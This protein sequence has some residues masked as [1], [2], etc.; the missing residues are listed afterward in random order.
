[1]MLA[2][3]KPLASALLLAA[4]AGNA[5]GPQAR[6]LEIGGRAGAYTVYLPTNYAT[7]TSL[8]LVVDLHG[9]ESTPERQRAIS[10]FFAIHDDPENGFAVVYPQGVANSWNAGPGCCGRA[11]AEHIDDVAFLVEMVHRILAEWPRID[12]G[13]VYATGLSNGSAM[14]QRL[15]VEASETFVAGAGYSHMLLVPPPEGRRP[16]AYVNF[17]GYQDTIVPYGGGRNPSVAANT[18]TWIRLEG[19][20]PA[21]RIQPMTPPGSDQQP[22]QCAYYEGCRGG[23]VVGSCSLSG[24]HGLYANWDDIDVTRMGWEFM[25]RFHR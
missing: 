15:G 2:S 10:G 3:V 25:K 20:K 1:M 14:T 13:R 9:F 8:P 6:T 18:E 4:G 23:V 24:G 19:C 11:E 17:A 22:N 12:A 16:F 5:P 21:P 7:R